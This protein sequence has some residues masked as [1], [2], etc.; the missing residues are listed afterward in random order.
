[1]FLNL[2]APCVLF[3]EASFLKVLGPLLRYLER[4][5]FL[6]DPAA[7]LQVR[8]CHGQGLRWHPAPLCPTPGCYL[9]SNPEAIVLDIDYKSGT[10]MQR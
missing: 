9:P 1:M 4:S 3:G 6:E 7:P 2:G 5:L 8:G 10:P